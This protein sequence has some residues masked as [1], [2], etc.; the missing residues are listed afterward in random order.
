M[1]V[2]CGLVALPLEQF[3]VMCTRSDKMLT[4]H[5]IFYIPVHVDS[6][7]N[8]HLWLQAGAGR[9]ASTPVSEGSSEGQLCCPTSVMVLTRKQALPS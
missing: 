4:L 6:C 8:K 5:A 1:A 9:R 7:L 3:M 2:C